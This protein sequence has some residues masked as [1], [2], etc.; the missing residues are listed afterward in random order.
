MTTEDTINTQLLS[1]TTWEDIENSC[2]DHLVVSYRTWIISSM[3]PFLVLLLLFLNYITTGLL[4]AFLLLVCLVIPLSPITSLRRYFRYY[5]S[6][7]FSEASI[8]FEHVPQIEDRP[9]ILC[10]NPHGIFSLIWAYCYLADEFEHFHWCFS[11]LLRLSPI[12]RILTDTT[13]HA[14]NIRK[15]TVVD[16]MIHK[17]SIAIIPGGWHEG[18]LHTQTKDR[19]YIRKRQ[20]FIKYALQYGYT[21][22]PS[23][24]FGERETYW[25]ISGAYNFRFRL[26]DY[27]ILTVLPFGQW[28][29]PILPYSEKLHVVIGSP[30]QLPHIQ[31]P[32]SENVHYWHS[33]YI[34]EMVNLYNRYKYIFYGQEAENLQLEIW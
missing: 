16:H 26:N 29:C 1:K 25:N 23:Y 28:W 3:S 34:S 8:R 9:T 19:L 24:G 33:I 17:R 4:V 20:G 18:T 14:S 21:I 22:T 2:Y 5:F 10:V 6:R 32:T 31:N 11:S 13:G 30:I 7:F 15:N 12:F 27:G